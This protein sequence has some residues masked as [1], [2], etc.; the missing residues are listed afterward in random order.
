MKTPAILLLMIVTTFCRAQEVPTILIPR[1][2]SPAIDLASKEVRRYIYLRTGQLP[3]IVFD[4]ELVPPVASL[5]TLV[6]NASKLLFHLPIDQRLRDSLAAMPPDGYCLRTLTSG[7]GS[8]LLVCGTTDI[9]TLYGAYTL[10]E[11]LG[12]RFSAHG[13]EIPDGR[14]TWTIPA[15]AEWHA[16]LFPTR[17]LQPFH[18]FPEGPDWWNV[19]DYKALFSQMVKMRMNFFGLHTY[20]QGGIGPE[21]TVWIGYREDILNGVETGKG[22]GVSVGLPGAVLHDRR[23]SGL[24]VQPADDR[25]IS[26]RL[27]SVL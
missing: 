8:I 3:N 4:D 9:G 22:T 2:P 26:L 10:V 1:T 20:P 23:G 18:D 27:R 11:K 12:V 6:P 17:G 5:I 24:G 13:D 14:I 7:H 21:P 16:P 25:H 15:M 19:D